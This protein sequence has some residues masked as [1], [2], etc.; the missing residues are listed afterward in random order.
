MI[1]ENT[2]NNMILSN[3]KWM[4]VKDKWK[5]FNI[6]KVKQN[7]NKITW[8]TCKI[9]LNFLCTVLMISKRLLS[10]TFSLKQGAGLR[11]CSALTTVTDVRLIGE[12][13]SN[14]NIYWILYCRWISNNIPI[15]SYN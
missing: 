4:F 12:L 5:K 15:F 3:L 8:C 6:D 10:Y 11:V 2:Q 9:G 7:K 14:K 13:V 1:F